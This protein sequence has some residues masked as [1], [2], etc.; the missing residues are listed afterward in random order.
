MIFF[1]N[2]LRYNNL[3]PPKRGGAPEGW[4]RP[5]RERAP[6]RGQRADDLPGWTV[7]C[8]GSVRNTTP[9]A[10]D[11]RF[12]PRAGGHRLG[13]P[14]QDP[15]VARQLRDTQ[16]FASKGALGEWLSKNSEV[17][18]ATYWANSITSGMMAPLG[19]QGLEPYATWLKVP[20]ETLIKHLPNARNIR[21]V[22]AGG[23]TASVW[24]LTDFMGGRGVSIDEWR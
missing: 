9:R 2:P 10:A 18:A 23:E 7:N 13:H 14:H 16:G 4:K 15:S 20:G 6:A 17:P 21:T 12:H 11:A 8:S 24:F 3:T 19:R 22:V 1:G 5:R